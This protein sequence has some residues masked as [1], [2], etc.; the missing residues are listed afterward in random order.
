MFTTVPSCS[1]KRRTYSSLRADGYFNFVLCWTRNDRSEC[2]NIV[3]RMVY[4]HIH[5]DH[6]VQTNKQNSLECFCSPACSHARDVRRTNIILWSRMFAQ[7]EC[8]RTRLH[9]HLNG[10]RTCPSIRHFCS[11]ECTLLRNKC[12]LLT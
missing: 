4:G 11:L 12:I 8:S 9:D 3:R 6:S 10:S 5:S 2:V 7:R 1:K